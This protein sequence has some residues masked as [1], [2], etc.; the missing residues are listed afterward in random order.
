MLEKITSKKE[1]NTAANR[2]LS[3]RRS[4]SAPTSSRVARTPRSTRK[5]LPIRAARPHRNALKVGILD[6]RS[7][8]PHVRKYRHLFG[9][10]YQADD[11]VGQE[12]DT[13]CDVGPIEDL[14]R[15][16]GWACE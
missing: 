10:R 16:R 12:H 7:N 5:S 2:T 8:Q 14:H 9:A 3:A 4:M 1:L 15:R 6:T 13:D 11:E